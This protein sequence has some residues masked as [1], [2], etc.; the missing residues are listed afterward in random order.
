MC[1]F[2]RRFKMISWG[3]DKE[4]L[5]LMSRSATL[6]PS[7]KRIPVLAAMRPDDPGRR[8]GRP[9]KPANAPRRRAWSLGALAVAALA[10]AAASAHAGKLVVY[11]SAD[12]DAL[13]VYADAFAKAHP[14]IQ[15][16]WVR[17]SSGALQR[18]VLAEGDRLRA[19]VILAH[20]AGSLATLAQSGRLHAWEPK[21]LERVNGRYL[22]RATP[23]AWVGL[24]AWSSAFCVN[25]ER[26]GKTGAAAPAKWADLLSPALK[27]QL[28]MPSP[29][30]SGT[31][32]L[33]LTA[34]VRMWG[35]ARAWAYMDRLHEN[36]RVYTRS[37]SRPCEQA[38]AGE[39]AVGL[40]FP[41]R[42]A[43]LR[44][45]GAP[46][47]VV[48]P[49]DGTGWDMQSVAI[50]KGTRNLKD[51]QSLVEWALTNPAMESF[52][53]YGELTSVKV[54]VRKIEFLPPNIPEKMIPLDFD[55]VAREQPRLIAEWTRRYGAKAEPDAR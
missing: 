27:G 5:P 42:G 36:V 7:Q 6:R 38:A 53:R 8:A 29:A 45:D 1:I 34:W 22:D 30:T 48:V 33:M 12:P 31:G 17:D 55:W 54:R 9:A 41:F 10:M 3:T 24:Y 37:G 32:A 28:V 19:D 47:D 44:G 52:A 4:W 2:Q 15:V 49:E 21:G 35:E 25:G 51:A 14:Q 13:K 50:V 46:I 11:S 26:L 39:I 40:S 23:P 43:R 18:K 16:E 20:P